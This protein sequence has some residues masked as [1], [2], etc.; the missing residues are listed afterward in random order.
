MKYGYK[1]TQQP[2][3][4]RLC[5]DSAAKGMSGSGF[6]TLWI[7]SGRGQLPSRKLDTIA[8]LLGLGGKIDEDEDGNK[9]DVFTW[10][11]THFDL[12]VDYCLR[13]TTLLRQ[14][15]EKLNAI[16]FLVAMQQFCGVRFQSTHRVTNY[17]RGLFGR[18]SDLKAPTMFNRQRDALTAANVLE[19]KA[20][21][22]QNVA[23]VDFASL[24]PI[25]IVCLNLCPTTKR[26]KFDTQGN[27]RQLSD[28]SRWEQDEKGVLPRI[29]EDM[30]LLRKEYKKL[31]KEA[32]NED[33][34]FKNEM[35][36]LAVKVTTNAIYGYVS[37]AAIGG[38]WT[39]PDVG[40][41]ITSM[42]R[43]SITLLMTE[44]ERQGYTVL[45]GHTDSCYIQ[46]PFE[47]VPPL[48]EHLNKT[49]RTELELPLMDVE[50]EAF[51]DYWTTANSKNRNFGIITWP[52]SKNGD[53]KVTGYGLKAANSS[54]VTKDIQRTIFRMISEGA[55]ENQV[56]QF[57]RPISLSLKKGERT[58]EEIAPYGRLGK[59]SYDRIPPN[60]AKGALYYNANMNPIEP[61]RVG[62]S[63]QW[64]YVNAVPKG[65]PST[66]I[67]SF[68]DAE[69]I[70]D[71]SLDYDLMVDKFIRKKLEP[72]YEVLEWDVGF[73]CGDKKPKEY[74]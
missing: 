53:L 67:V 6:E 10:W 44:A 3:K 57:I 18:Y 16:P 9:L 17:V 29:V 71:F 59:A 28:G 52:E 2:I 64:L 27:I 45:A 42:G 12:F 70:K 26:G 23:L 62:D 30:L 51:F 60:A 38:M 48:V 43:E 54:P 50:F 63:G 31:A 36:Q 5:F 15:D 8:K 65:L 66:N 49:I 40:A 41:A 55:E 14:C 46:A 32:I 56:S 21:R 33:D 13:D 34:K 68:R 39:D 73:A 24:Y 7:K 11:E 37:Q 61:F 35:M 1:E 20:G 25:L 74:W 58:A 72:I 22:H 4:G 47:E 19:T 69:E